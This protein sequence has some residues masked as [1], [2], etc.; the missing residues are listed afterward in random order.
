MLGVGEKP[1]TWQPKLELS[2]GDLQGQIDS[3]LTYI[4]FQVIVLFD[5][6]Y[7]ELQACT[8]LTDM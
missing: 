1:W 3:I 8:V 6:N 4:F 5:T 2:I 7:S